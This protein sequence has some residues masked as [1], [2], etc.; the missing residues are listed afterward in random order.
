MVVDI[1]DGLGPDRC[2]LICDAFDGE[3]LVPEDIDA[4]VAPPQVDGRLVRVFTSDDGSSMA[5]GRIDDPTAA[6]PA[7]PGTGPVAHLDVL[8]TDVGRR[9]R[10]SA[11]KVLGAVETWARDGGAEHLVVGDRLPLGL[12]GGVDVRWTAA[13]CLFETGE[14]DRVGVNVDLSCATVSSQPVRPGAGMRAVRVTSADHL[15]AMEQFVAANAPLHRGAFSTAAEW[16]TAV[17]AVGSE[18]GQVFGAGAHSLQRIGVVGPVVFGPGAEA[19]I[20]TGVLFRTLLADLAAAGLKSVEIQG[21]DRIAPFVDAV[22][23]RTSR[24]SVVLRRS[25]W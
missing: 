15:E 14:Y 25:L 17:I 4:L 19:R 7:A 3:L 5:I 12:F 23:A 6:T 10:G 11:R 24:V 18:S 16:G 8:V 13:L 9:R 2:S 21:T 1:D 20:V 22:G